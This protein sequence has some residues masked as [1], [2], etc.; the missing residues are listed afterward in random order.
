MPALN[1][2]EAHNLAYRLF[3]LRQSKRDTEKAEKAVRSD[4]DP[5]L[6]GL[7]A[8]H[9]HEEPLTLFCSANDTT[10]EVKLT[11]GLRTSIDGKR[12]LELGVSPEVISNATKRTET[13]RLDIR[14]VKEV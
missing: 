12:L 2:P 8:E 6:E 11:K 7:F 13:T 1:H 5:H 4:L 3:L 10:L 9:G 14:E